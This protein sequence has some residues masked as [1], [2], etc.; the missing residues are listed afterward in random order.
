MTSLPAPALAASDRPTAR[1]IAFPSAARR[2]DRLTLQDRAEALRWLDGTGYGRL[3]FDI[4]FAEDNHELGDFLLI[5][6]RDASWSCWGVGC[7]DGGYMVWRP[8]TSATLGWFP[9]LQQALSAIP[10]AEPVTRKRSFSVTNQPAR[11][12]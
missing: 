7:A 6:Q 4:S 9:T 2:A 3:A 11:I 8:A 12:A 5:Y 10:A 1:I